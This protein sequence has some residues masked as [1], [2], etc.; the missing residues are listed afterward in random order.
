[1]LRSLQDVELMRRQSRWPDTTRRQGARKAVSGEDYNNGLIITLFSRDKEAAGVFA[2][3]FS[4]GEAFN[5]AADI[6]NGVSA[7]CIIVI[8]STDGLVRVLV[9]V[10]LAGAPRMV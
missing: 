6:F 7:V 5:A 8:R 2:Q 3:G 1:M 9:D 4:W 10:D